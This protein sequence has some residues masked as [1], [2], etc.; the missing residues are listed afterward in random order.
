MISIVNPYKNPFLSGQKDLKVID[1][2]I[3]S[4]RN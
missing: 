1:R 2:A 4:V 3:Y